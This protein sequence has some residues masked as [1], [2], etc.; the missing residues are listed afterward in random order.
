MFRVFATDHYTVTLPPKHRF[1][2][3]KYR[4]LREALIEQNIIQPEQVCEPP[5][6]TVEQ[7]CLA[8]D[9]AYV[10]KV[11]AGNLTEQE[12]R[13]LGFPWSEALMTRAKRSVGGTIAA[14]Y[15]ALED[16][17]A[18]NLAGGTH[19]AH[20]D[21]GSGYCT[22]NDVAVAIRQ[23]QSNQKIE[24]ALVVDLDVH[25]GDGTAVIFANDPNVFTFSMHGENNFPFRKAQ[26]NLDVALSDGVADDVYLSKLNEH[27]SIAFEQ[28]EPDIVFY[29]GGTDPLYSDRLGKLNLSF[30][31]LKDRDARVISTCL[32]EKI[33][34]VCV[35]SGGYSVPLENTIQAHCNTYKVI[36]QCLT[37]SPHPR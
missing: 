20:A 31:G 29:L 15:A 10:Q 17:L 26:S 6:A 4:L 36:N 9:E 37:A 2:M 35:L 18:G 12:I 11:M 32:D 21:F 28:S 3:P 33:P 1:P 5:L 7:L 16:G 13:R 22:F 27:L 8:H 34:V 30:Q 19:H 25:Q 23:L 24:R 14:S